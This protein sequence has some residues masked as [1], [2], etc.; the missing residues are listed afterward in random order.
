LPSIMR[1]TPFF[2]H[3]VPDLIWAECD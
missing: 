3:V 1:V 2:V